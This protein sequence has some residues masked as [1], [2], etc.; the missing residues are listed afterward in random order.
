MTPAAICA[1][2]HDAQRQDPEQSA[3]HREQELLRAQ[4]PL[5]ERRAVFR[6]RHEGEAEA[7]RRRDEDDGQHVAGQERL[8]H[9]VRHHGQEMV[10]VGKGAEFFQRHVRRAAPDDFG[11]QVPRRDPEVQGEAHEGRREGGQ[12]RIGD[13]VGE[14]AFRVLVR[15]QLRQRGD[16]RQR[17]G[18]HGDE[19]EEPR[20]DGG[21]EGEQLVDL[22]D[23][24]AA[25][26]AAHDQRR[27]PK[28]EL[29]AL[30]LRAVRLH[31]GARRLVYVCIWVPMVHGKSFLSVPSGGASYRSAWISL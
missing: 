30:S 23:A 5:Q 10:I 28:H 22:G 13:G 1:E 6:L 24:H 15:A 17:D 19:L 4:E 20:E 11:G 14:N 12:E 3:D 18:R 27:D 21:D 16:D 25:Q 7:R 2:G 26:E 31:Y 29:P 9:V 8:E